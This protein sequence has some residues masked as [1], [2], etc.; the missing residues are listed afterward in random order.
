MNAA[1]EATQA[2]TYDV[3]S[4]EGYL[5]M[6]RAVIEGETTEQQA[7]AMLFGTSRDVTQFRQHLR[8][9]Q[10]R[11]EAIGIISEGPDV[12]QRLREIFPEILKEHDR[13]KAVERQLRADVDMTPRELQA[14]LEKER[15]HLVALRNEQQQLRERRTAIKAKEDEFRRGL[16]WSPVHLMRP[17]VDAHDEQI[18]VAIRE[19][20]QMIERENAELERFR[21]FASGN[22]DGG[23]AESFALAMQNHKPAIARLQQRIS[24]LQSQKGSAE[25]VELSRRIESDPY[26]IN[27]GE[28]WLTSHAQRG[29]FENQ[30]PVYRV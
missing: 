16:D 22:H 12:S 8:Q 28:N 24:D 15:G 4:D 17:A 11:V 10:Y 21:K 18:D 29:G 1:M 26:F 13:V 20:H 25:L 5:A 30:A 3:S 23:V 19:V 27:L 14:A 6:I 2:T 9:V 7:V